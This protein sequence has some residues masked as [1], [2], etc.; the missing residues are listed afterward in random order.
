MNMLRELHIS[1]L[2]V[3]EDV[4]IELGPG[5]NCFT[6]QTGAGKSLILG[7]FEV[8]LGLRS[9]SGGVADMLRPGADEARVSGLFELSDSSLSRQI[10]QILDLTLEQGDQLLIT[11]KFFA[12]GRSSISVNG[13]P[14][15]APMVRAIG[16][17]FVDIHGQHDH[18]YLLKPSNQLL[19]LDGFA[20]A[21]DLREKYGE[22]YAQVRN[23]TQ[24]RT[25]LAASRTLRRQQL[26][27]FEFQ[28]GEIDAAMPVAGEFD[29]LKARHSLLAN[30]EKVKR[31]AGHAFSALYEAEGSI[32]ERLQ[33]VSHVVLD[34][35]ELDPALKDTAEQIR[36][37]TL[38]L[39]DSAFDLNRYTER[40]ELDPAELAEVNDRLNVLNRLISKY[41]GSARVGDPVAEI[42]AFRAQLGEQITQLRSQDE[43]LKSIDDQIKALREELS[44]IGQELSGRRRLA[45]AKIKPLIEAQ[46]QELG[47]A[48]ASLDV[49]FLTPAQE[50][51]ETPIR[52]TELPPAVPVGGAS[53][54]ETIELLIRT[55]PGQPARPLRKI[56]SGGEMSRIMLAIKS[57]LAQ[58]DRVSVLVFDEIDANIGGRM[59]TVIGEKLRKLAHGSSK[60]RPSGKRTPALASSSCQQQIICITHLP[61]IAAYADRH[62]RIAKSVEGKGKDKQTRTTVTPLDGSA[63]IEELA[64][65]LAG[66]DVSETTRK[67]A[68]ELLTSAT[69]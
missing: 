64:E 23:L 5:L 53:G 66:K 69:A 57:I 52:T 21:M 35:A 49:E 39:Q 26:D 68:K 36:T 37:C 42:V 15:T 40:L 4:G 65:M 8:L 44:T 38:M 28:A 12:S 50:D 9:I 45:A 25:E 22:L 20:K 6:G 27:L 60:E 34:L 67:Q 19:I 24:R 10:G 13:H 2:A 56:A 43:D 55:N 61:Q 54:M 63:R 3:I 17:L 16:E 18:Q 41:A 33:M 32:I 47:M 7:A 51:T 14:A 11:R 48:D 62:L 31:D 59:G 1:N 46:L 29:E 58:S 30:M